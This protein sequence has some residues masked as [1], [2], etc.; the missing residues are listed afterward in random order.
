MY[1]KEINKDDFG[2][3]IIIVI[4]IV[5]IVIENFSIIV[6]EK[7]GFLVGLVRFDE[8]SVDFVVIFWEFL[9]YIGGC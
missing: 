6:L 8:V 9:V 1:I 5:G 3:Y 7:F 4:N 2:K